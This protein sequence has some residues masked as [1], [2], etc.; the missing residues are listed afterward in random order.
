MPIT[1]AAFAQ[2]Q[3]EELG[4]W[5]HD[6][7]KSSRVLHELTEHAEVGEALRQIA[8]SARFDRTLDVGVGPYG[9]GFIAVHLADIAPRIDGIEPLPRLTL[10]LPD[11][12][13]TDY[14]HAIQQRVNYIQ[15]TAEKMPLDSSTYDLATCIN[16]IDHTQ[17]PESIIR[18]ISRV[19]K[20]SGLL[21]FGVNTLSTLGEIK[22][23]INRRRRPNDFMFIAHPHTYQWASA[24]RL[25]QSIPGEILWTN[26]PNLRAR[27][28]GHAL[29]SFWIIRRR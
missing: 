2:A 28:A 22:W 8:G 13:L 6:A 7:G 11:R 5:Q 18:E 25:V 17:D 4:N 9:L 10:D 15:S 27:F 3:K 14:V 26:R 24:D 1:D 23:K 21:V 16:V 20:P 12:V 29:M 19:L